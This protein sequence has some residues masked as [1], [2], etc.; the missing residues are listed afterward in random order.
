MEEES[1]VFLMKGTRVE[2]RIDVP[3]NKIL[4]GGF[5]TLKRAEEGKLDVRKYYNFPADAS[6]YCGVDEL[7]PGK[8]AVLAKEDTFYME[9]ATIAWADGEEMSLEHETGGFTIV[10]LKEE[11]I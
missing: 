2:N 3:K 6:F 8:F 4:I 5:S 9:Y 7:N 1:D 10:S 11:G